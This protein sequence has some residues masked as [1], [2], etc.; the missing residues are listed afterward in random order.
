[1]DLADHDGIGAGCLDAVSVPHDA[2]HVAGC[3]YY[4]GLL[5]GHGDEDVLSVEAEVDGDAEGVGY[6]ADDV[7]D[8]PVGDFWVEAASRL[9]ECDLLLCEVDFLGEDLNPFLGGQPVVSRYSARF[10]IC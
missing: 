5:D 10:F 4:G 8:H 2:C 3:R 7:L 1:M 9:E 6:G